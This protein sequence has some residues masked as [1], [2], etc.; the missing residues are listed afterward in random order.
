MLLTNAIANKVINNI[1]NIV[2]KLQSN[3]SDKNSALPAVA[4]AM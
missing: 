3:R 1:I 4:M 2:K